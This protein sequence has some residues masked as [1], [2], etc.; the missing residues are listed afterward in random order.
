MD[1][2]NADLRSFVGV[3]HPFHRFFFSLSFSSIYS[4]GK[5]DIEAASHI[6][7]RSLIQHVSGTVELFLDD[8]MNPDI[9]LNGELLERVLIV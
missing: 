1:P 2:E 3:C 5:L 9:E 4:C 7:S 6:P 8:V